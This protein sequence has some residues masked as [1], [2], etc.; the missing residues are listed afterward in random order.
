[1]KTFLRGVEVPLPDGERLLWQGSPNRTE[2]ALHAFHARKIAIYFAV[3]IVLGGVF[4]LGEPNAMEQFL[5]SSKWLALGGAIAVLFASIVATLSARTTLYAITER[6]VVMKVGMALPVVLNLPLHVIDGVQMRPRAH[7]RGDIALQLG[8]KNRVA[9]AV[10]WPHARP[11]RFRHPEPLLRGVEDVAS[12]GAILTEALRHPLMSGAQEARAAA[13]PRASAPS[14]VP[15]AART[16]SG[17][18]PV[19]ATHRA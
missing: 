9:Y 6:R 18:A 11:W 2:L 7:G 8:T 15:S 10:L 16:E 12:V 4:A 19:L 1:M 17:N 5:A 13:A 3:L 14:G